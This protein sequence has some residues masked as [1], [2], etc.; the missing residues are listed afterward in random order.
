LR[1]C[2]SFRS[3]FSLCGIVYSVRLASC[4]ETFCMVFRLQLYVICSAA[5]CYVHSAEC[6]WYYR[7]GM[8]VL[9][10]LATS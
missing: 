2:I 9:C 8:H 6:N 7:N 3:V 10:C 1:V 4:N 5:W